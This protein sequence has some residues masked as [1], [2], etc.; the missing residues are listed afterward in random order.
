VSAGDAGLGPWINPVVGQYPLGAVLAE[1]VG[2][3]MAGPSLSGFVLC[4]YPKF[5][6]AQRLWKE[7]RKLFPP[8]P[9]RALG[10]VGCG[11]VRE[12]SATLTQWACEW[13]AGCV[14]W[15]APCS[16]HRTVGPRSSS[17]FARGPC[18]RG[19]ERE[20]AMFF[21]CL[22]RPHPDCWDWILPCKKVVPIS[23]KGISTGSRTGKAL[24][25]FRG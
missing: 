2:A 25:L 12:D 22:D 14:S 3:V 15:Q 21:G 7:P 13:C 9:D 11:T 17:N 16:V 18:T 8:P 23:D 4:C 20:Q 5:S 10:R 6:R 1:L 24:K 19:C